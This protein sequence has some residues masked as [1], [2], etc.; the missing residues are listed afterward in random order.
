MRTWFL[1]LSPL[2]LAFQVQAQSP[3]LGLPG[4]AP[5]N[6]P[7]LGL[8]PN[9]VTVS[10]LSSGAFMAVQLGVAYSDRVFGVASVAGGIYNCALGNTQ[11]ATDLCMKTPDRIEVAAYTKNVQD[12]FQRGLIADPRNISRQ[13]VFI[14][15]GS[16]DKVVIPVAGQ[17][18]AEFYQAF[19]ARPVVDFALRMGHAFPSNL[20]K[21]SCEKSQFPWVNKCEYEGAE[22]IFTTMY[23]PLFP[24][25][26]G[27][28][29][30]DLSGEL[31]S[32]D[33]KP[34]NSQEAKML[35]YGNLYVPK[36][37]KTSGSHCRLHIALHGCM[38]S[39]NIVQDQFT[40]GADYN[41][42]ADTNMIVVLYPATTMGSGNSTGCWDWFG[43]TNADYAVRKSV[44]M[45][46]IMKMVETLTA[47]R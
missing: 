25:A 27:P 2:L 3:V 10:G 17:K 47:T 39:P 40:K 14:L 5:V 33:Q 30:K 46:A 45:T 38:Q 4:P 20:G 6:L 28:G 26:K 23:G 12:S 7:S 32:F 22:K 15:N 29:L 42:W 41:T 13:K 18:L 9:S 19:G 35:D 24:P 31:I 11:N 37:C 16:E 36:E 34:F 1:F 8:D 43:Y 21:N 44:Q